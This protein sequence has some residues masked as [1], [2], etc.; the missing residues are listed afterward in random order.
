MKKLFNLSKLFLTG[1]ILLTSPNLF[2]DGDNF[3]DNNLDNSKWLLIKEPTATAEFQEAATVLQ[4]QDLVGAEDNQVILG[5]NRTMP[6][7]VDW[8]EK[9]DANIPFGVIEPLSGTLEN[10]YLSIGLRNVNDYT[11]SLSIDFNHYTQNN[12]EFSNFMVYKY[13]DDNELMDN[14]ISNA[15]TD[16]SSMMI[17]WSAANQYFSIGIDTDGGQDNFTNLLDIPVADWNITSND[18]F[19]V[20]ISF[21][22]DGN[23]VTVDWQD[24]VYMDNFNISSVPEPGAIFLFILGAGFLF[25]KR[26]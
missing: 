7:N 16:I 19:Q 11:D 22:N 21:G 25:K 14:V 6:Y 24:N 23:D 2:A 13:T 10:I 4:C 8:S 18:A 5:W 26:K 9:I 3:E 20:G 1:M 17:K 15:Y 12:A